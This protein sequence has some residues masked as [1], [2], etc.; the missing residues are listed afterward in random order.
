MIRNALLAT[1][2]LSALPVQAAASVEEQTIPR[3]HRFLEWRLD[4]TR[5]LYI[6]GDNGRWYYARVARCPRLHPNMR[7]GFEAN[8]NGDFDRTS[9]IYADAWRCPVD[10]VVLAEP[11]SSRRH[12]G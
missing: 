10:S 11:P 9:A 6:H 5:G 12:R 3:I 2:L 1:A 4:A 8:P 7:L